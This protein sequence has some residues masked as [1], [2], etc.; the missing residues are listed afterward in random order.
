MT[1]T[2]PLDCGACGHPEHE[3]DKCSALVSRKYGAYG[4]M[5]A[6]DQPCHCDIGPDPTCWACE[7]FPAL[8]PGGRCAVCAEEAA[9]LETAAVVA[10]ELAYGA[11]DPVCRD[12]G[13]MVASVSDEGLCPD[14]QREDDERASYHGGPRIVA[15]FRDHSLLAGYDYEHPGMDVLTLKRR[16]G[17]PRVE[18]IIDRDG[19]DVRIG[20]YQDRAEI[21]GSGEPVAFVTLHADGSVTK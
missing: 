19:D 9:R 16:P 20:V 6:D 10:P 2:K 7:T 12:C 5:D 3:A 18:L 14:C 11:A 8:V 4:D 1:A 15:P 13:E 17:G 21:W